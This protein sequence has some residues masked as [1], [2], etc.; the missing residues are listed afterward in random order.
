MLR[1]FQGAWFRD[2][3]GLGLAGGLGMMEFSAPLHLRLRLP[4]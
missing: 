4:A 3:C 2:P 1:I